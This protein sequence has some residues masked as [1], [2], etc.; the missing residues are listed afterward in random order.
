[1]V[2]LRSFTCSLEKMLEMWLP[3]VFSLITKRSA[4]SR[5]RSHRGDAG[6]ERAQCHQESQ[7][8]G[9]VQLDHPREAGFRQKN[10]RGDLPVGIP[11]SFATSGSST[12]CPVPGGG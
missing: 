3:T 8:T 5:F 12:G 2:W 9:P 7:Q 4:I 11:F 10:R 6:R 1:M